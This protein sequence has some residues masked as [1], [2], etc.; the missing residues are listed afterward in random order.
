VGWR[1]NA[2][3]R[4]LPTDLFFPIGQGSRAQAQASFAKEICSSCS[5]RAECLD[6]ALRANLQFG[7]FGGMAEDERRKVQRRAGRGYGL[8]AGALE[9]SA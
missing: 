8:A 2:V 4:Q 6:F 9:E 1:V 7:V 3:C 5:V